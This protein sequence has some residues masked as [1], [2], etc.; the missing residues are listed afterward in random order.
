MGHNAEN[1]FNASVFP[2][3]S[4]DQLQFPF[5]YWPVVVKIQMEKS[6][7]VQQQKIYN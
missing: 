4:P 6:S 7:S 2:L 5:N 3:F 1:F